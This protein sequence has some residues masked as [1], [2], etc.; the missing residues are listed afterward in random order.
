MDA[1]YKILSKVWQVL[2]ADTALKS[3]AKGVYVQTGKPLKEG[4]PYLVVN[5]RHASE[6]TTTP[7]LQNV[8]VDLVA[9]SKS[10]DGETTE[11][12]T[13]FTRVD[14]LLK[15]VRFENGGYAVRLNRKG[16]PV[17]YGFY[18]EFQQDYAKTWRYKGIIKQF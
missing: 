10:P 13:I 14:A 4:Y 12:E 8:I 7:M 2:S 3:L 18:D 17:N 9:R 11:L 16:L 15:D 6:S 1:G 5:L